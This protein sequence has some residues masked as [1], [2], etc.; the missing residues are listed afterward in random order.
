MRAQS[1]G[2]QQISEAMGSLVSNANQTVQSVKEFSQAA[3][4]LQAAISLL[5]DTV[6]QFKL[7][8]R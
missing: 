7:R 3:S 6:A 8:E 4:D 1:E 2:A 5:R